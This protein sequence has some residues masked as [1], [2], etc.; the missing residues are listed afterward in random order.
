[1]LIRNLINVHGTG[2]RSN[3]AN[4]GVN[5]HGIFEMESIIILRVSNIF[6]RIF[7]FFTE[8][9]LS[10]GFGRRA[11][12]RSVRGKGDLIIGACT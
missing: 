4:F 3:G 9:A 10:R 2:R 12:R 1:M 5:H 6:I 8:P 7:L 11:G